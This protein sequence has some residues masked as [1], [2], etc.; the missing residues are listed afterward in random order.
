MKKDSR[1]RMFEVMGRLDKTFKPILNEDSE[2]TKPIL[3]EGLEGIEATSVEV[4]AEMSAEVPAEESI[5]KSPE[6]KLAELTSKVDEIYAL[7]HGEVDSEEIAAEVPA[8]EI[9]VETG[10]IELENLQEWNFDKKKGDKEEKSEDKKEETPAEE[11]KEEKSEDKK[12]DKE[13][14][15]EADEVKPKIPIAAV[16]KVGK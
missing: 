14:I 10:E 12:E 3:N 5:E 2:E 15:D 9:G 8:E 6:E 4:P 13:E 16:A 1:E 7:V 11:K